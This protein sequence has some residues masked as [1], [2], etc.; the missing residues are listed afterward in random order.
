MTVRS[1]TTST[2]SKTFLSVGVVQLGEKVRGPGD[3]VRLARAGRVLDEILAAR[4]VREHG[5]LQFARHV[6]LMKPG[7]NDLLIC[8]FLSRWAMR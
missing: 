7:E 4:S 2:V 6:E 1:E 3:G 8:F 5:H